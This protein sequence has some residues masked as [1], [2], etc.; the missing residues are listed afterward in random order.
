MQ[1]QDLLVNGLKA[2][3]GSYDL[4][5]ITAEM[6][7]KIARGVKIEP[8]ALRDAKIL[9]S[10][11]QA[12]ADHFGIAEGI[13]QDDLSQTG[14]SVIFPADLPQ[15]S[16]EAIKEA[17]KPLLDLRRSQAAAQSEIYYREVI[18]PELGYRTSETK[19]EFLKRF[20]RG[21]GPADPERFPY[22]TLL[23]G[24]PETIPFS[25]QSQLDVQ[26]GVGRIYFDKLED[27]YRYATAVVSAETKNFSRGKKA[28]FF[29]PL[30]PD[31]PVT[32]NGYKYQVEPWVDQVKNRYPDWSIDLITG[33]QA[34]K[35]GFLQLLENRD[36]PAFLFAAAHGL[37]LELSDPR[38]LR[39]QGALVCQDWPGPGTR[40]SINEDWYFSGD[41]I[42]HGTDVLGLIAFIQASYSGGTPRLDGFYRQAFG[43]PKEIAPYSFISN[44]PLRL[45]CH[46]ALGSFV[47]TD[48]YWGSSLI[49][50]G[51]IRRVDI[52]D[53]L[54]TALQNGKPAGSAMD[55]FSTYY[56]ELSV[57]LTE[58]LD[59]TTP[60]TQDEVKLAGFWTGSA[61]SR[62]LCFL[63]DP[64]VRLAISDTETP[65]EARTSLAS[66][67]SQF[68]EKV[69]EAAREFQPDI[70]ERVPDAGV[71]SS[72]AKAGDVLGQPETGTSPR[73][74]SLLAGFSADVD[75]GQDQLGIT[76][77]VDA[78]SKVIASRNIEPPLCIGLFG[79]W[80]S[81]KSFFMNKM[82]DRIT[83]LSKNAKAYEKAG[84]PTSYCSSVVQINF[85][86]WHYVDAD[87]WAS[88]ISHIFDNLANFIAQEE[89]SAKQAAL[90]KELQSAKQLLDEAREAKEQAE[91]ERDLA[92]QELEKV[93]R[94]RE[95]KSIDL[96]RMRTELF[97]KALNSSE[98]TEV[99]EALNG[100]SNTLGIHSAIETA[101]DVQKII[102]EFSSVKGRL[103]AI[104]LT[105]INTPGRGWRIA[106]FLAILLLIPFLPALINYVVALG[107]VQNV[108]GSI[109]ATITQVSAFIASITYWVSSLLSKT[110]KVVGDLEKAKGKVDTILKN[111]RATPGEAELKLLQ[112]IS[113]L[114]E[115]EESTKKLLAEAQ[116]RVD[117]AQTEIA[118]LENIKD[119]R[120][121]AQ[122]VRERITSEDYKRRLG[123]ISMVRR[124]LKSL[125]DF[126]TTQKQQ[127][128][129]TG[130]EMPRIDRIVLY[131]DDLD[132]CPENRVVEVLQ[133]LHLLLAFKLFVVVVG[134]DSR[135][136]LHSMRQAYPGLTDDEKD[137]GLID[138]EKLAWATT[139]QNYLEKIFQIPYNL[140]VMDKTGYGNLIASI[141]NTEG[142]PKAL[143]PRSAPLPE[144]PGLGQAT[145]E[146]GAEEEIPVADRAASAKTDTAIQKQAIDES[147]LFGFDQPDVEES[148]G[149]IFDD[150]T[151]ELL[152]LSPEE[153]DF[154]KQLYALVPTPRSVK[155]MVNIYRLIRAKLPIADL[156]GFLG[157][158]KEPGEF[159]AVLTLLA[160]LTG[161]QNEAPYFFRQVNHADDRVLW[162]DLLE[163][164][165]PR[166]KSL[167]AESYYNDVLP[168]ISKADEIA[169]R[170]LYFALKEVHKTSNVPLMTK[171]Y[172]KWAQ[173]VAR[174]SFRLGKS[175]VYYGLPAEI[176]IISINV[177][178]QN[179]ADECVV[180]E[181]FGD[182]EQ[183]LTNW[184]LQD[185]EKHEFVFPEFILS[186]R[187]RVTIWS[188]T[189]IN[190]P[191]DLYWGRKDSIWNNTGD[192]A[193]LYDK[194]NVL[195]YSF[196]V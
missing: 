95:E 51:A 106:L 94:N 142:K 171:P 92:Q 27:Y 50:D 187:G 2:S 1:Q 143:E 145:P 59:Y 89:R 174:F 9:R 29:C 164:I 33:E 17:L 173:Q 108:L 41:D 54:L 194:G 19:N 42:P 129:S 170:R 193:Y 60:E 137:S 102:Q 28:A 114:K 175:F 80:G 74:V 180:I 13:E 138:E 20:G 127:P 40:T 91:N 135:W 132:R 141:M 12:S 38:L 131:I 25:F 136:L 122:F 155:R 22:Y 185:Q 83:Y 178:A 167:E 107:G 15:K 70:I 183:D 78:F 186:P 176:K 189:G 149:G 113:G 75:R 126:L 39:H 5:S 118:A 195:I 4:E 139:P 123:I 69:S 11:E 161:F 172:R 116:Q 191:T 188:T 32:Q 147:L 24:S 88:L 144:E 96:N 152:V 82:W 44:L 90:F 179:Q 16:V 120:K 134:V 45:L 66:L 73:G 154:F 181:N 124:D 184:R 37:S 103:Q 130:D 31:D 86:A 87:L 63:G 158:A 192:T 58:E 111:S 61:D 81:G 112:E 64:A 150:Q 23:V 169:W 49:W 160:T 119:G 151:P 117:Q 30:N 10:Q 55:Y 196:R 109:G 93:Q 146:P 165:L 125:S 47:Y 67:L 104:L 99:K 53:S 6:I 48:R 14:W 46:G 177:G 182:N 56:A 159:K 84:N 76:P 68:P 133:A 26:Y 79:D 115:R 85:N 166:R 62:N 148:Y 128:T 168:E 157:N 21:P 101:E 36:S 43:T 3:S 105:L 35:A 77:D 110:S 121:L 8:T 65:R 162:S 97:Q 57:M 156:P 98:N 52:L 190:K 153:E 34:S 72:S 18:G 71:A 7:T 140:R 100:V 163:T